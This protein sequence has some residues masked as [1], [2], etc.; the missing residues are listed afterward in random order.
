MNITENFLE[1]VFNQFRNSKFGKKLNTQVRYEVFKPKDISVDLWVEYLGPNGNNLEH[2]QNTYEQSLY[3]LENY[4]LELDDKNLIYLAA[5]TH[6][7]GEAIVG[8]INYSK[9]NDEDENAEKEAF[10]TIVKEVISDIQTQELLIDT[11]LNIAMDRNSKLGSIFNTIERIGYLSDALRMTE[12]LDSRKF[13]KEKETIFKNVIN[14]IIPYQTTALIDRSAKYN[15]LQNYL[16]TNR[17]NLNSMLKY[18][19]EEFSE[20]KILW[21]NILQDTVSK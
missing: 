4:D 15:F 9:K 17:I 2:M 16:I 18:I 11:Y 21:M 13:D 10:V 14:G 5:L 3:L 12:L 1:S 8:D 20:H 19:N 6:D 7:W